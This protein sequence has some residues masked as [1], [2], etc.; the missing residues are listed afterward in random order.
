MVGLENIE[1][2]VFLEGNHW[3]MRSS[4]DLFIKEGDLMG[5][6]GYDGITV[7]I[8]RWDLLGFNKNW[9]GYAGV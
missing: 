4:H 1:V 3:E 9:G 6:W 8:D 2:I 7:I 5:H